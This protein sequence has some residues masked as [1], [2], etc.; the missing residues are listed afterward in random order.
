[1]SALTKQRIMKAIETGI[2]VY[3]SMTQ[4]IPTSVLNDWLQFTVEKQHPPSVKGKIFKL[5]TVHKLN[6]IRLLLLCLLISRSI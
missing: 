2:Q 1:M 3:D 6:L 5:S 4:E